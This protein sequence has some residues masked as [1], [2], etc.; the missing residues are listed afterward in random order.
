MKRNTINLSGSYDLSDNLTVEANANYINLAAVGRYG[1]GYDE[2]NPMQVFAQWFQTNVDVK[3]LMENYKSPIDGSHRTW[4]YTDIPTIEDPPRAYYANNPNWV[5]YENYN[6][7]GR[8]RFYGYGKLAYK[9][10]GWG[11]IEGRVANDYYSEYQERRIAI[12][13]A[14]AGAVPDYTKYVRS[15]DEFNADLML[16]FQKDLSDV[17]LNGLLGSSTRSNTVKS[18][19]ASTVGGLSIPNFFALDNSI[20]PLFNEEAEI[21]QRINSYYG[22]LSTGFKRIIYVDLTARYDISST[23]PKA[24]NSYFYQIGRASCR[25][26]V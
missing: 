13:S 21:F 25:E 26:R 10:G 14:E 24:N 15:F 11:T 7:D 16:R 4:N 17:S 8:D 23:L 20:A 6:N 22:S 9:L 2:Q 19:L 18:T 1:T 3:D 12:G 5:R